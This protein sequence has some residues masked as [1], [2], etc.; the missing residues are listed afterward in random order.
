MQAG[1]VE[2]R[3][4]YEVLGVS[5]GADEAECKRAYRK[6]AMKYHPDRNP[7]SKDA[8][9][10]FKEAS[11]AY[12]VL[13]DP[14]K[15]SRYDR[16]GHE[17]LSANGGIN[18]DDIFAPF[19]DILGDF[20][21]GR[22]SR[23]RSGERRGDDLQ[24]ELDLDFEEAVFGCTKE[25]RV[26]RTERCDTC[27]GDG[28]E[29]G[30]RRSM[31][32]TCGGRGQVFAQRGFFAMGQTCHRCRGRGQTI[33]HPCPTCRGEGSQRVQRT[34]KVDI[35]AGIDNGDS[36]RLS[37]QG[38]AGANGGPSGDLYVVV[39]VRE[40][41]DFERD[42]ADLHCTVRINVAQAAL[43]AR[44]EVPTLRGDETIELRPGTRAGDRR[45]LPGKG[46]HRL[47]GHGRGDLYA[48]IEVDIP[49]K[50]TRTQ[51]KLFEELRDTFDGRDADA[52]GGFFGK[53]RDSHR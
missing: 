53:F 12:A 13:S 36:M 38:N 50:L 17:G 14:E 27:R 26:P 7:D 45:K 41:D 4:Y 33:T 15:R 29:P 20:F 3:D 18:V 10:R 32:S 30:T 23:G 8:E 34:K 19:N 1:N 28:C 46:V 22:S 37:G 16:F 39:R 43:G 11:E 24:Y 47:R 25:L 35:P 52:D 6:L 49:K 31:C 2:K 48:H 9:E 51:R 44:V 5:R 40:H 42:G 21:G